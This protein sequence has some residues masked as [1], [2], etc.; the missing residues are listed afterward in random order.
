[1]TLQQKMLANMNAALAQATASF[2]AMNRSVGAPP[3]GP[4]P[5]MPAAPMSAAAP[6]VPSQPGTMATNPE[7]EDM[8]RRVRAAWKN[9]QVETLR[10]ELGASRL[11]FTAA[12]VA[13]IVKGMWKENQA[14]GAQ[15]ARPFCPE[16]RDAYLLAM[17]REL[18]NDEFQKLRNLV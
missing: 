16:N 4:A 18:W 17:Q 14:P 8:A 5:A 15:V 13:T 6:A 12:Q 2:G 9:Q 11:N 10:M 1:M 3:P 7:V